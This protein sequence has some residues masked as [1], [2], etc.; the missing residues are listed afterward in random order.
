[1][2]RIWNYLTK[3]W[4]AVTFF[5]DETALEATQTKVVV[6]EGAPSD[7][8][9]TEMLDGEDVRLIIWNGLLL[10]KS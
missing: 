1:M 5:L 8:V 7:P 4:L 2:V 10:L 6:S 9:M 3:K